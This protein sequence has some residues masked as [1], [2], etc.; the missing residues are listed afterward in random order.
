MGDIFSGQVGKHNL[1]LNILASF[2][3][4]QAIPFL[5]IYKVKQI[6]NINYAIKIITILSQKKSKNLTMFVVLPKLTE[7][8][9]MDLHKRIKT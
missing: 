5:I 9:A 6:L 3:Q 1:V 4:Y 7:P 2:F 8:Y